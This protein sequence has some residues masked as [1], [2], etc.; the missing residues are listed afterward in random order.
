MTKDKALFNWWQQFGIPFYPTTSLPPAEEITFPY[1]TYEPNFGYF[2]DVLYITAK[3]YYKTE[4][5]AVPNAKAK[6]IGDAIGMGGALIECDSG[7]LWLKRGSPFAQ[8][9]IDPDNS[10]IKVR[11]LQLSIEDLTTD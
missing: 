9:I 5:E 6:E 11:Y 8:G 1:G 7:A 3:L 10:N 2:G 4:S